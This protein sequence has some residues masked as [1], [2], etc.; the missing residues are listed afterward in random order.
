MMEDGLMGW[1]VG[2]SRAAHKGR[3]KSER[4]LYLQK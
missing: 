2:C 1:G 3:S 4:E